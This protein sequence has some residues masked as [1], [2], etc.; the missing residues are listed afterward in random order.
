MPF[1]EIVGDGTFK[2]ASADRPFTEDDAR[3]GAAWK[4][5][6]ER[7]LP[8]RCDTAEAYAEVLRK[9]DLILKWARTQIPEV[10]AAY[11]KAAPEIEERARKVLANT[12]RGHMLRLA[13]TTLPVPPAD[14]G[15]LK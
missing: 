7:L 4:V 2:D 8:D 14:L 1:K 9:R 13:S 3:Y 5:C 10:C 6:F 11:A 12:R 15:D